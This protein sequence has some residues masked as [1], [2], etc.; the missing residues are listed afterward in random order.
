MT[1]SNSEVWKNSCDRH[2]DGRYHYEVTVSP[3]HPGISWVVTVRRDGAIRG[4]PGGDVDGV[5]ISN[6]GLQVMAFQLVDESIRD[7]VGVQ[8]GP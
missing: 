2:G 1:E 7:A 8:V 4:T 6:A 3:S 5:E